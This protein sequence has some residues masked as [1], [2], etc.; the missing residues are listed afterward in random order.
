M[1]KHKG[2]KRIYYALRSK[3]D[4]D[5]RV[6]ILLSSNDPGLAKYFRWTNSRGSTHMEPDNHIYV[7]IDDTGNATKGTW[8][9]EFA[10]A[11]QFLKYGHISL[12][13]DSKE[14]LEREYEIAVCLIEKSDRLGLSEDDIKESQKAIQEYREGCKNA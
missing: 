11:L 10:H 9:E 13:S 3:L 12:S 6:H 14:S 7:K 5:Q 2:Y 8:L 4:P 1:A